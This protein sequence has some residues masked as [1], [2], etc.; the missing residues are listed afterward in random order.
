M[1]LVCDKLFP[2]ALRPE[3][4]QFVDEYGP[5]VVDLILQ[6]VS[7]DKI[8]EFFKLCDNATTVLVEEKVKPTSLLQNSPSAECLLC[9]FFITT[10]SNYVNQNSSEVLI[11]GRNML[12]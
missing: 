9:E 6:D 2:Q 10:L 4:K 11:I 12:K 7:P 1:E 3:C 5:A 8:C